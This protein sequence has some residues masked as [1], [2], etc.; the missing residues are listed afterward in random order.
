MNLW[1]VAYTRLADAIVIDNNGGITFTGWKVTSLGQ[2]FVLISNVLLFLTGAI[3]VIMILVAALRYVLSAGNLQSTKAAK[4]T[5]MFALIGVGVAGAG[6][7]IIHFV[8]N[9]IKK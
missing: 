6:Y 2:G 1:A 4:D 8:T 7:A 9:A 3:S 5:A